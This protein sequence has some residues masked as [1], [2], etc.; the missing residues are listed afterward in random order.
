MKTKKLI[1]MLLVCTLFTAFAL[2]CSEENTT[3]DQGSDNNV[4]LTTEADNAIGNYTVEISECRFAKD[5]EGSDVII[6]KYI[7]TNISG[8]SASAFMYAFDDYAFQ[9][10]VGLNEAYILSDDANYNAD[11][12]TKE[13]KKGASIDVEVAYELN[14][15][16]TPVEIEVKELFSLNEKTLTKTFEIAE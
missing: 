8:E 5:Y 6:V 3:V 9:N 1:A 7:F 15:T 13:I 11:N 12:Q 4:V 2:A 10:G 16:T 14:D